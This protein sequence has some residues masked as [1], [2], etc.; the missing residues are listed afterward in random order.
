MIPTLAKTSRIRTFV[1]LAAQVKLDCETMELSETA[2]SSGDHLVHMSKFERILIS[3]VEDAHLWIADWDAGGWWKMTAIRVVC[4]RPVD[5]PHEGMVCQIHSFQVGIVTGTPT[6]T[7][8]GFELLRCHDPCPVQLAEIHQPPVR[9]AVTVTLQVSASKSA[10]ISFFPGLQLLLPR[11]PGSKSSPGCPDQIGSD[12]WNC[13]LVD[14]Q[15]CGLFPYICMSCSVY[16]QL[17][18]N[19]AM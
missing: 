1:N 2:A 7:V 11:P 19:T 3:S 17:Q 8:T 14:N 13:V 6:G 5:H 16:C 12:L 10:T 4:P 15:K 9:A 18:P